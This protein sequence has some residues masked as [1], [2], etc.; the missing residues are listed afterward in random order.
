MVK[1]VLI[2]MEKITLAM[3][4]ILVEIGNMVGLMAE[5]SPIIEGTLLKTEET[6]LEVVHNRDSR[7]SARTIILFR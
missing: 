1:F 4:V 2:V 5:I 6:V 7:L 3:F